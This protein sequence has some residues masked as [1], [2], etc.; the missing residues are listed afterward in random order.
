MKARHTAP[1]TV[2]PAPS[3]QSPTD[4]PAATPPENPRVK[5]VDRLFNM[6]D[7]VS[8]NPGCDAEQQEAVELKRILSERK[9]Q[10][11]AEAQLARAA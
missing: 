3:G 1:K 8:R 11:E 7:T 2:R 10:I 9:A 5:L 4:K 6:A